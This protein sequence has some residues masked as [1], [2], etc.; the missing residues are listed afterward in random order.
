MTEQMRQAMK[1]RHTVRQF[2][3]TPLTDSEKIILTSKIDELNKRFDLTIALIESEKTPMLAS[4]ENR[5]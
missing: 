2:D 1:E 3:G 5:H 4:G